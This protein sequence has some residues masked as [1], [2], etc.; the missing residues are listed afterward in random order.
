MGLLLIGDV[1]AKEFEHFLDKEEEC[2][3]FSSKRT[4][5]IHY[6]WRDDKL[7]ITIDSGAYHGA[8]KAD[9]WVHLHRDHWRCYGSCALRAFTTNGAAP[10]TAMPDACFIPKG[11]SL[12][13]GSMSPFD[14]PLPWPTLVAEVQLSM[15]LNV[16]IGVAETLAELNDKAQLWLRPNTGVQVVLVFKHYEENGGKLEMVALQYHR[17]FPD[18]VSK[19]S[20]GTARLKQSERINLPG[21]SVGLTGVEEI[22]SNGALYPSCNGEGI[23]DYQLRIPTSLVFQL[24]LPQSLVPKYCSICSAFNRSP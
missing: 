6:L 2:S 9:L 21:G 10:F 3:E 15:E 1:T 11:L 8:L 16:Q 12:Q 18:P 24:E 14:I 23:P 19:V 4:C 17:G 22:D 13:P 20:F 5:K 7:F